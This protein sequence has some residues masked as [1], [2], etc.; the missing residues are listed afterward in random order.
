MTFMYRSW[1]LWRRLASPMRCKHRVALLAGEGNELML[2]GLVERSAVLYRVE[3]SSP[4]VWRRWPCRADVSWAPGRAKSRGR[5][6]S[7]WLGSARLLTSKLKALL[8]HLSARCAPPHIC[9]TRCR[10]CNG[11][12]E[13]SWKMGGDNA[14]SNAGELHWETSCIILMESGQ[15]PAVPLLLFS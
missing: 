9:I 13:Y 6:T 5:P 1:S 11:S 10:A 4:K 7:A 3:L 8:T 15:S 14:P 12:R 2:L